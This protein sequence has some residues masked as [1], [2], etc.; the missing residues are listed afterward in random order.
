MQDAAKFGLCDMPAV[1]PA[2]ASLIVPLDEALRAN[3]RCPHVQCRAVDSLLCTAYDAGAQM[4]R[5][6]NSLSHLIRGLATSLEAMNMEPQ[7]QGLADTSLQAFA[8]M[9][10][11]L[12]RLL[13]V[14]TLAQRQV[15]LAQSPLTEACR[16]TLQGLPVLSRELFGAAALE[17]LQRTAQASQ[18]RQ[19]LVGLHRPH[20]N[21]PLPDFFA[22]PPRLTSRHDR[23]RGDQPRTQASGVPRSGQQNQ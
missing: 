9:S 14:L 4:G 16:R 13:D 11:E 12:S 1:E 7:T 19:Q 21:A 20:I 22:A 17:A 15:W 3:A 8:Y 6:G 2:V 10:L 18:T 5:I 23:F